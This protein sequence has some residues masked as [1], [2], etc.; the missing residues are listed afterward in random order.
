MAKT[1]HIRKAVAAA[2]KIASELEAA[3]P[4]SDV[5]TPEEN[6][7]HEFIHALYDAAGIAAR[8]IG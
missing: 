1:S 6:A 3:C 7:A 8:S 5:D 4:A 2:R